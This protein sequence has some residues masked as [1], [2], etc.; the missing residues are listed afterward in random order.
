MNADEERKLHARAMKKLLKAL[1]GLIK[2]GR[3]REAA[4]AAGQVKPAG[5]AGREGRTKA[6]AKRK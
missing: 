5:E 4:R 1:E 6:S 2:E 3:A